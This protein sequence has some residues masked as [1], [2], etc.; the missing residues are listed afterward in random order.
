MIYGASVTF[1]PDETLEFIGT[2]ESS[3][4]APG[5]NSAGTASIERTVTGEARYKVNTWWSVWAAA[6]WSEKTA[7]GVTNTETGFNVGGGS[8]YR[9][10][11]HV[12]LTADYTFSQREVTATPVVNTHKATVGVKVSR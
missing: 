4:E 8:E 5:P 1:R 11:R 10:N 7:V 3:I 12:A 2:L 9:L 6:G